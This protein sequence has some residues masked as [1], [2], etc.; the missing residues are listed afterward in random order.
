M[1]LSKSSFVKQVKSASIQVGLP[2]KNYFVYSFR[3][4]TATT[5][6][7]TGLEDSAI[8]MLGRWES[9]AFKL[10]IRLDP[11]YLASLSPTLAQCQL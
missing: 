6:A 5:T 1:P 10:C 4:G 7:V 2:A 3:I 8:Q 11:A 9:L